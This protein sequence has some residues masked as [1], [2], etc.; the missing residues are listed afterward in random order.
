MANGNIIQKLFGNLSGD[1]AE[2]KEKSKKNLDVLKNLINP[3]QENVVKTVQKVHKGQIE[4]AMAAGAS[5]EQILKDAGISI[6]TEQ[7]KDEE[8]KAESDT[9][10]LSGVQPPELT[11]GDTTQTEAGQRV[12]DLLKQL[13]GVGQPG[14]AGQP[15]QAQSQNNVL[16][17]L[18]NFLFQGPR[19]NQQ[20]GLLEG[21]SALG[22]LL[23]DRRPSAILAL[24]QA[25]ALTPGAKASEAVSKVEL[26]LFKENF[27][28]NR[29]DDREVLK[30]QLKAAG[31]DDTTAG[32][33]V[34]TQDI[35]NLTEARNAV[36][37][38]GRAGGRI[39]G[40]FAGSPLGFQRDKRAQV[41]SFA[42]SL[43][44]SFG[45]HIIAQ[46]GRAFVKDEQERVKKN[47]I[48]AVLNSSTKVFNARMNAIIKQAN[49]RLPEGAVQIP[50]IENLIAQRGSR[51]QTQ[52]GVQSEIDAINARLDKL[53][54]R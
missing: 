37:G 6:S 19:V 46:K 53:G 14:Q 29:L 25:Q 17:Q 47:V 52:P 16:Q 11:G 41:D 33:K 44:F 27:K 9:L 26:D 7:P 30:A 54:G 1:F 18:G 4:E 39:S 13:P 38:K 3:L 36:F 32:L 51:Q 2:A 40:L 28:Q 24:Q 50:N 10:S 20:T 5:G 49:S 35:I 15:A 43:L 21:P 45:E 31:E 8:G 48:G 12:V 22:G 23:Q 42:E 34:L